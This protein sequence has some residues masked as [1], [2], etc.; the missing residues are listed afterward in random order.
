M[1]KTHSIVIILAV[2]R[3]EQ[4]IKDVYF[5]LKLCS[6]IIIVFANIVNRDLC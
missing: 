2:T 5:L 4:I 6:L 1:D 3:R